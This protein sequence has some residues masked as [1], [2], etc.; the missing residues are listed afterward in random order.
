MFLQITGK[1]FCCG[2]TTGLPWSDASFLWQDL[3]LV[4][5]VGVGECELLLNVPRQCWA[6]GFICS[7]RLLTVCD[8]ERQLWVG[9]P[10]R[11]FSW[12]CELWRPEGAGACISRPL[13]PINPSL[14]G[15]TAETPVVPCCCL[16]SLLTP[17]HPDGGSKLW[18]TGDL[19]L[20]PQFF[21]NLEII[22][23]WTLAAWWRICFS[24]QCQR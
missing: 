2:L 24:F 1:W 3:N 11:P 9:A 5:P 15:F 20:C 23:H 14:R 13:S 17:L 7:D 12:Q 19:T 8:D 21:S 4:R 16:H 18:R 22:P 10:H 6:G